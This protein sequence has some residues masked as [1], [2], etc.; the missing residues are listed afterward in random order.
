MDDPHPVV[1]IC[2]CICVN[3]SGR[4]RKRMRR[5]RQERNARANVE[6]VNTITSSA[7]QM[8]Q[9]HGA[10]VSAIIMEISDIVTIFRESKL[11]SQSTSIGQRKV[12]QKAASNHNFNMSALL[13][14]PT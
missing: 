11:Q 5:R 3:W 1:S 10:M 9:L 4:R 8:H 7:L 13:I 6:E 12:S 14:F 2:G